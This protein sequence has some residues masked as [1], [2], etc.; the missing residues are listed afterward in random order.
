VVLPRYQRDTFHE[1]L[2]QL[3]L[4]DGFMHVIH[5]TTPS[6]RGRI[7]WKNL[8]P[9]VDSLIPTVFLRTLQ[10][11]PEYSPIEFIRSPFVYFLS[12]EFFSFGYAP[13]SMLLPC[14]EL[15]TYL[16]DEIRS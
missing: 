10:A 3:T 5:F 9:T 12:N 2:E 6:T 15:D 1:C 11:V 7:Y 13:K 8:T 14:L 4:L 16:S